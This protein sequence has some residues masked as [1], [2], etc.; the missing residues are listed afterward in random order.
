MKYEWDE[1]KRQDNIQKHGWD[2]TDARK[3]WESGAPVV[4]NFSERQ[5]EDRY[6]A[7][8]RIEGKT[9]FIVYEDKGEDTRRIISFRN[10]DKEERENYEREIGRDLGRE[11]RSL[12]K[13]FESISQERQHTQ[14]LHRQQPLELEKQ[15]PRLERQPEP[16]PPERQD[17]ER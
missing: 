16:K 4:E 7:T 15:Q 6:E 13:I 8:G 12:D 14:E 10:A 3:A 5:G 1:N 2:F 9:V 11:D 17:R